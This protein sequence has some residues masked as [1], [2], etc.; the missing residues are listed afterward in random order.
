MEKRPRRGVVLTAHQPIGAEMEN[1]GERNC[2]KHRRF[3]RDS[4]GPPVKQKTHAVRHGFIWL[5]EQ[6]GSRTYGRIVIPARPGRGPHGRK[7]IHFDL[8][9]MRTELVTVPAGAA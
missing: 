8:E 6:D 9:H 1:P 5:P 4:P 2:G 7:L 3:F